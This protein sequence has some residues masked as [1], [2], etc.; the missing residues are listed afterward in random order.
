[1]KKTITLV[2]LLTITSLSYGQLIHN[3]I[4]K[5]DKF[6]DIISIKEI[7]TIISLTDTMITIETKGRLLCDYY[8]VEDM[9][10]IGSKE[11]P[12]NLVYDLWGYETQFVVKEIYTS[13]PYKIIYRV[14]TTQYTKTYKESLF[15]VEDAEGNKTIYHTNTLY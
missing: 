5:T 15:W 4:T 2:I 13:K 6:Q 9:I 12:V 7:K 14:L 1:M 8:I 10:A 11:E 3:Y